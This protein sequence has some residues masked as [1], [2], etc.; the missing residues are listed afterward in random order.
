VVFK[1]QTCFQN[2]TFDPA[3]EAGC[4]L[5]ACSDLGAKLSY[6]ENL[7]CCK[8][9][10]KVVDVSYNCSTNCTLDQSLA[11]AC[12]LGLGTGTCTGLTEEAYQNNRRCCRSRIET[13]SKAV[14]CTTACIF[15]DLIDAACRN[16]QPACTGGEQKAFEANELCCKEVTEWKPVATDCNT[17]CIFDQAI[18][19]KG[20][21]ATDRDS[22][23]YKAAMVTLSCCPVQN[24]IANCSTSCVYN[25]A[26]NASC[27]FGN[28]RQDPE[29]LKRFELNSKCCKVNSKTASVPYNSTSPYFFSFGCLGTPL[30]LLLLPAFCAPL[31]L[32]LLWW[33]ISITVAKFLLKNKGPI[34]GRKRRLLAQKAYD[35]M[36]EAVQNGV[37]GDPHTQL[38]V[39]TNIKCKTSD[40]N[41][42]YTIDGHILDDP[43]HD[44]KRGHAATVM[45]MKKSV[46][47]KSGIPPEQQK[48]V[49][50]GTE[51]KDGTKIS[52]YNIPTNSTVFLNPTLRPIKIKARVKGRRRPTEF[53]IDADDSYSIE[54]VKQAIRNAKGLPLSQ[55]QLWM[56]GNELQAM[57][58]I[59]DLGESPVLHLN[60]ITGKMPIKV[61]D[62]NGTVHE[63]EV[64]ATHKIG[65]VKK[66]LEKDGVFIGEGRMVYD[67]I[68]MNDEHNLIDYDVPKGGMVFLN[69]MAYQMPVK[70]PSGELINLHVDPSFTVGN[71]KEA[72]IKRGVSPEGIRLMMETPTDRRRASKAGLRAIMDMPEEETLHELGLTQYGASNEVLKP[73]LLNPIVVMDGQDIVPIELSPGM[74][75]AE[76]KQAI[77]EVTKMPPAEQ[78][79]IFEPHSTVDGLKDGKKLSEYGITEEGNCTMY[80][81]PN[82][83]QVEVKTP[84]GKVEMVTVDLAEDV[85]ALKQ[86]LQLASKFG[87][88]AFEQALYCNGKLLEKGDLVKNGII[89][90]STILLNPIMV[91]DGSKVLVPVDATLNNT[92]EELKIAFAAATGK[93]AGGDSLRAAFRGQVLEN[94]RLVASYGICDH[95]QYRSGNAMSSNVIYV[96]PKPFDI[97]VKCPDGES[98][99]VTV[100]ASCTTDALLDK[101]AVATRTP[102]SEVKLHYVAHGDSKVLEPGLLL[103]E[104]GIESAS[105]LYLNPNEFRVFAKLPNNKVIV[106]PVHAAMTPL[107]VRKKAEP[108]AR[109]GSLEQTIIVY[110]VEELEEDKCLAEYEVAADSTL[111]ICTADTV[112]ATGDKKWADVDAGNYF[113]TVNKIKVRHCTVWH[114]HVG[115]PLLCRDP[116]AI[117]PR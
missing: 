52:D 20:V 78:H 90:G 97:T 57:V 10:T 98:V 1:L 42:I 48:L 17:S 2:C 91:N 70:L 64:K 30:W 18:Y 77:F 27:P 74:T 102:V 34:H 117:A 69:P 35:I 29:L 87:I 13:T 86:K 33:P 85:D 65:N 37:A 44:K 82:R 54:E 32:Y 3:K 22:G 80:L 75:V 40:Q 104:Y 96:D 93:P 112:R 81:N 89:S 71:L 115:P 19:D 84:S 101:V 26:I 114:D 58:G 15:N 31:V 72:L 92:V 60:P 110:G 76:V 9:L 39:A 88:P 68:A 25:E 94:S 43:K 66:R 21:N 50:K 56:H 55:Q 63:M 47:E 45:E 51:L 28:C 41:K 11:D 79:I 73:L 24:V 100:D 7:K 4:P 95:S 116:S 62:A 5:G 61:V 111:R 23:E 67:G 105:K 113:R 8:V 16:R 99:T 6:L 83:M 106:V 46:E 38:F 108:I 49:Y 12:V 59:S 107:Q 36:N 14:N 103:S 109:I 53:T